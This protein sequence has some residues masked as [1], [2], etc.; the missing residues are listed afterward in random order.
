MAL[1]LKLEKFEGPLDLLLHLI[2]K[3]KV[4]I[5][6]IP[7]VVI[8]DQ[9]LAYIESMHTGKMEA[10]SAFIEMA[11][12]LI[13]IKAKMLLPRY[14][15]LEDDMEDPR[16]ILVQR[17]LAYKKYKIISANL[18]AKYEQADKMV[19]KEASI[20]DELQGYVQKPDVETLLEEVNFSQLFHVFQNILKRNIEKI[21]VVR[22]EFGDIKKEVYTIQGKIEDIL[23][24]R[25][26]Y[27][28]LSFLDLLGKMAEK[29]EMVV[30][31]LALLELMKMGSIRVEQTKVFEDLI[32]R[33]ID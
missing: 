3:N 7:I 8:T 33:F 22:S 2:D 4:N 18:K 15:E 11:A 12:I 29:T 25:E 14:E 10:M 6:D 16:D 5:Y 30:T 19:F 26:Q 32:I 28:S 17:L 13:G 9:Y 20:P 1:S 31:F 23:K 27:Q 21:D 24:M